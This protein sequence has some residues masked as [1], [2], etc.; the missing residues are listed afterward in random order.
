MFDE[1]GYKDIPGY[2]GL[3][4]INSSGEVLSLKQK[5]KQLKPQVSNGGYLIIALSDSLGRRRGHTIHRLLYLT[6]I[7]QIPDHCEVD[8]IN[9]V[10]TDNN[11]NNLR[12]ITPSQN[13]YNSKGH[14][15]RQYSKFKGITFDKSRKKWKAHLQVEGVLINI[16]RYDSEVQAAVNYDLAA[17]KHHGVYAVTNLIK[18][19][20][21]LEKENAYI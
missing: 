3:Y 7:G 9:R 10:Q 18:T 19:A 4:K 15:D 17:I 21:S 6:F 11:L 5:I 13:R 20:D 2:E 12:L 14:K 1:N 8:H 16:G